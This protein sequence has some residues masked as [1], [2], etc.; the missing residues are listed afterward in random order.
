MTEPMTDEELRLRVVTMVGN[1]LG[2]A[3]AIVEFVRP[4]AANVAPSRSRAH[5]FDYSDEV[6]A[7][8]CAAVDRGL[9]PSAIRH[10]LTEQ[11]G[12]A[13]ATGALNAWMVRNAGYTPSA[14]PQ[15]LQATRLARM[16][17][18]SNA[19]DRARKV[20]AE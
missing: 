18:G 19:S 16:K 9:K 14:T 13:P 8:I 17:R 2:L 5:I 15:Q 12:A 10:L 6:A 20:A 1:D 7:A 11:F 4:A 3:R